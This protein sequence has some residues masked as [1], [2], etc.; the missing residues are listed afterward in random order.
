MDTL[1]QA[2]SATE[3]TSLLQSRVGEKTHIECYGIIRGEV[4]LGD[5]SRK[6]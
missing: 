5:P 3:I 1:S 6:S 2:R 4:T